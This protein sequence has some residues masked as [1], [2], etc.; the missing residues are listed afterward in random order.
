[1][2][3]S[4]ILAEWQKDAEI[5]R[6]EL[7]TE[8]LDIP[9]LHSKYTNMLTTERRVLRKLEL[10]K[11]QLHRHLQ[12]YYGGKSD[13]EVYKEKPFHLKVLKNDLPTYIQSDAD[14]IA[15]EDKIGL[16]EE[17]VLTLKDIVSNINTRNWIIKNAID[18]Q[19]FINGLA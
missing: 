4:Q 5:N 10:Q 13:A 17:K 1:M 7:D 18:Y 3:L 8:S 12:E 19:K 14:M 9:K 16:Q 2:K 11:K 6:M 15:L